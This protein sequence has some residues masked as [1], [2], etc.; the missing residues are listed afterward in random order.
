MSKYTTILYQVKSDLGLSLAEYV[1]LDT[2]Y[3]LQAKTGWAYADNEFYCSRLDMTDRNLRRLKS[4]M[5]EMDLLE[6]K[7]RGVR[8]TEKWMDS[9]LDGADKMSDKA[10][11]MSAQSGQNVRHTIEKEIENKKRTVQQSCTPA[12]KGKK[13]AV[14]NDPFTLEEYLVSMRASPQKH[15]KIIAEYADEKK[16]NYETKG[17]WRAFTNRN[18]KI[19]RQLSE[20]SMDQIADAFEKM[21]KDVRSESNKNP[22]AFITKWTLET[23]LKYII[24]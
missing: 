2:V 17:Q 5:I 19:A 8:V 7:D 20:F 6:T 14:D 12:F 10:D 24:E 13:G 23:V 18:L 9:Y 21:L 22:K 4:K 15:I 1:Y 16:P 11:K 3:H